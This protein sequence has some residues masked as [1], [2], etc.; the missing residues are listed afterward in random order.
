MINTQTETHIHSFRGK[1]FK[2]ECYTT[3]THLG[4]Q[5]HPT[6]YSIEVDEESVRERWW[7]MEGGDWIFDVGAAYGS[8]TLPALA[9]GAERIFAWCLE[10]MPE[11]LPEA[12]LLPRSLAL[13]GWET[14]GEVYNTGLYS[15]DGWLNVQT[16]EFSRV[17]PGFAIRCQ[18]PWFQVSKLDTWLERLSK[19][20]DFSV[21]RPYWLKLDVEGAEVEVLKGAKNLIGK[22][23]P[24]ILLENHTFKDA[25]IP[26]RVEA[27]LET[28]GYK[29]VETVPYHAVSHSFYLPV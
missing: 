8:Y 15:K 1:S 13:N 18:G 17:D 14:R 11:E 25:T 10:G 16:Q 3:N 4:S 20:H 23:R 2:F 9:T 22:L 24:R 21:A 19:Q 12:Q 7:K 5:F 29:L 28:Y 6:W 26:A 27:L